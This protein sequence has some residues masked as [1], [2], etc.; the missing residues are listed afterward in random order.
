M[1]T[2]DLHI[3]K[4]NEFYHFPVLLN[5]KRFHVPGML[6]PRNWVENRAMY[7]PFSIS[8]FGSFTDTVR[9]RENADFRLSVLEWKGRGNGL[10]SRFS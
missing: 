10:R 8:S 7:T 4:N 1:P 9:S 3:M 5:F 2:F 6:E